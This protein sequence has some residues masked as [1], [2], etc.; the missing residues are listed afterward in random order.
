MSDDNETTC[1]LVTPRKPI[2][3][4]TEVAAAFEAAARKVRE[5]GPDDGSVRIQT[6]KRKP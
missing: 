4:R 2:V 5:R 3:D 1:G 6:G